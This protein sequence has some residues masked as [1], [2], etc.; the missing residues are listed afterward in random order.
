MDILFIE[1]TLG[2]NIDTQSSNKECKFGEAIV[3]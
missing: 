2:Y 1:T 3:T